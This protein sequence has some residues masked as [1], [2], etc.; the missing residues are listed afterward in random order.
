[1]ST[2]R[3]RMRVLGSGQQPDGARERIHTGPDDRDQRLGRSSGQSGPWL[4]LRTTFSFGSH[5]SRCASPGRLEL[6]AL[7]PPL[8][9]GRTTARSH[10]FTAHLF[11]IPLHWGGSCLDSLPGTDS[12]ITARIRRTDAHRVVLHV[13]C[14]PRASARTRGTIPYP[15]PPAR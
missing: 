2:G 6:R 8:H 14:T 10:S 4:C 3:T 11:D 5:T 7:D 1:W 9:F 15:Q 13:D 12:R